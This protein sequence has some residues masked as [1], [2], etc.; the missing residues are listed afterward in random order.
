MS[1][2]PKESALVLFTMPQLEALE[3]L[4]RGQ[5]RMLAIKTARGDEVSAERV[6][7]TNQ[8]LNVVMDTRL[9]IETYDI[10]GDVMRD[11]TFEEI[12]ETWQ[13]ATG[14]HG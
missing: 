11:G 9:T 2:H 13:S 10:I 7:M 12:V 8:L 14:D 1:E 5:A 4:L 3:K 6:E